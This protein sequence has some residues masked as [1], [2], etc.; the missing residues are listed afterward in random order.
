MYE[1][2]YRSRF[3][4]STYVRLKRFLDAHAKNLGRDDKDC[5]YYIFPDR[6]LKIVNNTSKR[7]AKL[8]L[9]QNHIGHGAVFPETEV[10]FDPKVLKKLQ[11]IIGNLGL[12]AKVMHGPQNR[13]NY[14]YR[15]CEIALKYSDAWGYHL[16]I[17]KVVRSLTRRAAAEKIIR[18]VA[19]ELDVH[20]MS[21][22]E[23]KT[24]TQKA[25][26]KC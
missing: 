22:E 12:K 24:F 3:N 23:L 13:I 6:L 16:E 7:T 15:G 4:H 10:Y 21:E 25:E 2:E 9:K 26:S 5:N 14:S 18:E 8:S 1:I 11:M 17:E 19:L 20:L